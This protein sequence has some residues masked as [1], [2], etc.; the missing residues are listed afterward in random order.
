[1]TS[2]IKHDIFSHR[3]LHDASCGRL[4]SRRA[5]PVRLATPTTRAVL[6]QLPWPLS[7]TAGWRRQEAHVTGRNTARLIQPQSVFMATAINH[8]SYWVA[9]YGKTRDYYLEMLG[10]SLLFDDGASC[11]VGFGTPVRALHIKQAQGEQPAPMVDTFG[12]S[13]ADFD[14]DEVAAKLDFHQVP[15]ERAD[16]GSVIVHDP[17]GYTFTI[18]PEDHLLRPGAGSGDATAGEGVFTATAFNHIAY[19]VPDHLVCRDFYV[20]LLGMRVAFD[21]GIKRCSVA[22]GDE[23]EDALYITPRG[24]SRGDWK[25]FAKPGEGFIDHVAYSVA[26]FDLEGSANALREHGVEPQ[27]DGE[28]AWSVPDGDGYKI[29]ICAEVGVYPGAAV[30]T[31]HN[32]D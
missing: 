19:R 25:V 30:D 29:Q 27:Y 14:A 12:V 11:A 5:Q 2:Y 9:D 13:I 7:R 1:M 26:D 28:Y 17:V 18:C 6:A 22:F 4:R 23:P 24:R 16:D 8:L 15:H 32:P 10:M 20:D 3:I 21:D 31:F